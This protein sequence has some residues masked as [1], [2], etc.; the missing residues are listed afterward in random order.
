[1]CHSTALGRAFASRDSRGSSLPSCAP[2][3]KGGGSGVRD[4]AEHLIQS[5]GGKLDAFY[6]AFGDT[7]AIMVADLPDAKSAVAASL[8]A[9][10]SG[11]VTLKTTPLVTVEE[12]DAATEMGANFRP[13]GA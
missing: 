1:M 13:L 7:D 9:N 4:L 5:F 8:I 2:F 12:V 6:Y 3:L 10:S 11:R